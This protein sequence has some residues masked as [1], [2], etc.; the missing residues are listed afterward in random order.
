MH[1]LLPPKQPLKQP[2]LLPLEKL[3]ITV[4]ILLVAVGVILFV[5]TRADTAQTSAE[6]QHANQKQHKKPQPQ[7]PAYTFPGGK[8]ELTNYTLVALY[9]SPEVPQ[10]GILGEQ[11]VDATIGRAK[12]MAAEYQPLTTK[13]IYPCLEIITTIA[14][15]EPTSNGDY[16]REL[17]AEKI[18]PWVDAAKAAGVYV[19][20]DLQPGRSD[21]LSQ[22]KQYESLLKQPHVGLA[23]DPEWRLQPNEMHLTHI[24]SVAAEEVNATSTWLADLAKTHNLPQ[25]VFLLHQFRLDMLENRE[26][27]DTSREELSFIVQ[28]DGQ[29][30]QNVKQDT[31]RAMQNGFP[32]GMKLGW[33][34]FTD[35]DKPMLSPPETMQIVPQP[36]YIS[37]Q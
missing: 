27:I 10:L 12:S 14:A 24:G 33:K 22:A 21:F 6:P 8:R 4:T 28:M 15:G 35:E 2:R 17:D 31:W 34:N 20:L 32:A 13:P 29:G 26:H 23:L 36:V 37:Y 5:F 16:S 9:G 3:L 30:A 11:D 25:K 18:K 19:V 7:E 1:L